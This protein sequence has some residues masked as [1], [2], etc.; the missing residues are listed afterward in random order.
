MNFR[1]RGLNAVGFILLIALAAVPLSVFAQ[2]PP[3]K[4]V[5]LGNGYLISMPDSWFSFSMDDGSQAMLGTEFQMIV[6]TPPTLASVG[7]DPSQGDVGTVLIN[8]VNAEGEYQIERADV[9]KVRYDGRTGAAF[10]SSDGH[11]ERMEVFVNLNDGLYGKVVVITNIGGL[12]EHADLID[13]MI[14]S[15]RNYNAAAVAPVAAVADSASTSASS[16]SGAA[17]TVRTASAD[18]AQLR[19]GPGTNRGAISFLPTGI[20]VTV[21]GRIELDGGGVWYQLDKSQAAP[22]G[23][24]AAELW[25]SAESVDAS[26]DCEHVGDTSAPPIIP[27][28]PQVVQPSAPS[29]SGGGAATG[30]M[31]PAGGRWTMT[32]NATTNASCQ[33]YQNVPFQTSEVYNPIVTTSTLTP[34]NSDSFRYWGTVFT[35]I[36]GTNSFAGPYTFT[37]VD[38]VAQFRFDVQSSSYMSGQI[39]ANYQQDGVPCSDTVLFAASR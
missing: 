2:T 36:P 30:F 21:T 29:Q 34:L 31:Q 3:M 17:C 8:A 7:I 35:R 10:S 16:S 13:A 14:T 20:D 28:A 38:I 6:S 39:V 25:V 11:N 18:G 27:L 37:E 4:N 24:A 19:V 1:F 32:L 12:V 15:L 9:A 26:G 33:G 23:S 5:D 22:N